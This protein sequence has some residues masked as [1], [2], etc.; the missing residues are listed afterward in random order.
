MNGYIKVASASPLLNI[1]D[2]YGNASRIEALLR[3]AYA[4]GAQITVFPELCITGYT[5]MDLFEQNLLLEQ[6]VKALMQLTSNTAD[7][8]SLFVVGL[9]LAAENKLFNVAAVIQSGSLLGL[10]PKIY[11]PN[12]KEFQEMRW[13][14]S[15]KLLK[16][17]S[18]TIDGKE[19]PFGVDL[20]FKSDNKNNITVGIE[21]CEDLWTPSPPSSTLAL[22]GADVIL[23][24]SASNEIIGKNSYLRGLIAQQSARCIAGYVYSSCGYGESTT[25]VVFVGKGFIAEN[26]VILNET[27]E[28]FSLSD[29][30]LTGD[31]DIDYLRHD[32]LLNTS[33]SQS[34]ML[35]KDVPARFIAWQMPEY[36]GAVSRKINPRPFVPSSSDELKERCEEILNI[37]TFGLV[38]R[39]QHLNARTAVIGISGGLDSTLALMVTVRAFD[40]LNLPRSGILGVTMPGFGTTGRTYNNA[41]RLIRSL[42][43]TF[44]EISIKDACIQHFKDIGHDGHTPDVTYE[45]VQARERTQILMDLANL[46]GGIVIGT[47]DLSELALGWATYNGDHISMYNVNVSVP[48]TLVRYLVESTARMEQ[49]SEARATLLDVV[50]TPVS[51]ELTPA[52]AEGNITQK[53]EDIVGPYELH[54]F[55]L[56]HFV[57]YGAPPQKLLFLAVRAYE[58]K[59]DEATVRKWL[60]VFLRRFFAQQFKRSCLPD[61]PKVGSISLSPRSDWR[62]PSDVHSLQWLAELQ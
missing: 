8:P 39:L 13:F 55:F 36:S 41:V 3:S 52:D 49:N 50:E 6:A 44:K 59:Y 24:L 32:R 16:G 17:S 45:N 29:K 43:V 1:A 37:Q 53:T 14:S 15:G 62:M 35:V 40:V 27:E 25:D 18:V 60:Q 48:K 57:R 26:G 28:R 21:L 38:R 51:P 42:Q 56:Y 4:R 20:L 5:C 54:D 47:G 46:H 22:Q 11:L 2:C 61:G 31:I 33:F 9:P 34:T 10:V 7:I 58:G 30:L 12:Y 19:Y 23:N